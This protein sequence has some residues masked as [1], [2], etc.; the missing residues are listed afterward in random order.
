MLTDVHYVTIKMSVE[1]FQQQHIHY[2][3]KYIT[4]EHTAKYTDTQHTKALL[5]YSHNT[6]K[7]WAT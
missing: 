1:M 4:Y 3:K 7:Q 2:E 5:I 6:T